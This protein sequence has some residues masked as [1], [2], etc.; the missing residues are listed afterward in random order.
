M[1]FKCFLFIL[2]MFFSC[3]LLSAN[4]S[5]S[6]V[7]SI[8]TEIKNDFLNWSLE[9][10]FNPSVIQ[11]EFDKTLDIFKTATTTLSVKSTV[12]D[13]FSS[14]I[15]TVELV[16]NES[17]CLYSYDNDIQYHDWTPELSLDG[18][19]LLFDTPLSLSFN[20]QAG[21]Y[22]QSSNEV[23]L[24]FSPLNRSFSSCRGRFLVQLGVEL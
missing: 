15:Y 10:S 17:T 22:Q 4:L 8:Y 9:A 18:K 12:P 20:Q 11:L 14:V 16:E 13:T 21:G 7:V 1:W 6:K 2:S 23:S 24:Q 5:E 19:P 3:N